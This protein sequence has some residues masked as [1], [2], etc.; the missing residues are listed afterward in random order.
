MENYEIVIGL[1]VHTELLTKSKMF[2]GCSTK[3]GSQPNSQVCPVCAGFPGTLPVMNRTAIELALKASVAFEC[4]IAPF[5]RFARKNYF[6][7]DLPKNYQISQ[8]EEPL[9]SDGRLVIDGKNIRL[10]R[11]HMEEDAGKLIHSQE[12]SGSSFVD[13]NRSCVPLIEIVTEPDIRSSSEAEKFLV[14][15]K[16]ILEYL[17][18]SDCNMEEGSLRCDANISVRKKGATALGV[19]TEIKNMNSFKAVRKALDYEACR[20]ISAIKNGGKLKQETRLWNETLQSTEEMRSKEEAHDYRYFPDPDLVPFTVDDKWVE[21][22]TAQVGELPEQRKERF[23]KDYSLSEY[24]AEVLTSSKGTADFFEKCAAKGQKPKIIANWI[25]GNL[26]ALLKSAGVKIEDSPVTPDDI[27]Q[28]VTQID[29]GRLTGSAAK[30]VLH[31]CFR[32]GK[33]PEEIIKE[34]NL[35][36][37]TDEETINAVINETLQENP[38]ALQDYKNGKEQAVSFLIGQIMRK[39]RGQANPAILKKN[40]LERLKS[41]NNKGE[42]SK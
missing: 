5:S 11:I 14:S 32:T 41:Q 21:K 27:I 20:Q 37:I 6:Y 8:Y 12:K 35:V 42:D 24:D 28:I 18:V 2:C 15:L 38:K 25:M 7:P 9:A 33:K 29:G 31:E 19:K 3:F 1:E 4:K 40:L 22:I 13:L 17:E 36:H 30:T 23:S 10:K 34:K 16:R 26:S 39:T